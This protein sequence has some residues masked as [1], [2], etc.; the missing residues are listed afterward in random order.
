VTRRAAVAIALLAGPAA[1][2]CSA[3]PIEVAR[4]QPG[5]LADG[6][7]AHWAFDERMGDVLHDDSGNK[8]DGQITGATW[9]DGR[10]DG[11]LHFNAGDAVAVQTFPDGA[12]SWSVS[13]WVRIDTSELGSDYVT[14]VSSEIPFVGGWEVN[15]IFTPGEPRYHFGYWV[16]P[17]ESDYDYVECNCFAADDW[18]HVAAVVDGGAKTLTLYVNGQQVQQ[19]PQRAKI[20]PGSPILYMARWSQT[21][22]APLR[23]LTGALDDIAVWS[24][25]LVPQEITILS[26]SPVPVLAPP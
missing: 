10:F 9:I 4:L 1:A 17:S 24:R 23:L 16:G 19:A 18:V 22:P 20:S 12:A 7:V 15:A 26:T 25:P 11:A 3:G 6:M 21:D 13:L 14:L 5:S 2:A 8:R